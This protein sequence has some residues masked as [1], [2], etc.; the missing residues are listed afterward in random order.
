M[1]PEHW[2]ARGINYLS[3]MSVP[4]FDHTHDKEVSPNVHAELSSSVLFLYV[5]SSAPRSRAWHLPLL[6]L[7]RELQRLM[8]SPLGL[9][10]TGQPQCPQPLLTGNAFQPCHQ[11]GYSLLD[12]CK[13]LNILFTL[14]CPELYTTF[15][16]RPHQH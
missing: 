7:L 10:Q 9:L 11:L 5:L 16:V 1:P 3:K 8:R 4:V 14:Q 15:K 13:N 2:Q 6:P 12:A